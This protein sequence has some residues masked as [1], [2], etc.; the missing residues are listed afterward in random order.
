MTNTLSA[1]YL[2]YTKDIL[3]IEKKDAPVRRQVQ[4]VL[5]T[6]CDTLLRLWAPILVHTC[7]EIN[8]FFG[9]YD[10]SIHLQ[11]FPE[12]NNYADAEKVVS[13]M[14]ALFAMR[15]DVF[16]AIENVRNE[17]IIGKPLEA[18]VMINASDD[19]KAISE[20]ILGSKL[21]Q[22]LTVSKAEFVDEE[23][24]AF[25]TVKV[26]VVKCDG[27]VCPRCW[28]ITDSHNEDGLCERCN[29]VLND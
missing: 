22:W 5:Y 15:K 28:N 29:H 21:N 7:E 23:L 27:V 12:V 13:D 1:Y 25:D 16:K 17:K 20:R 2:D 19:L 6:A 10:E 4:S 14:E 3:Y 9:K 24:E 11:K 18:H 8:N 26:K